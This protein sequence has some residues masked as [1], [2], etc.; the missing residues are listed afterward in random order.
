[1]RW[2][3][4]LTATR[5]DQAD[6]RAEADAFAAFLPKLL[7]SYRLDS[8]RAALVG[9]SNGANFIA[10]LMLLHPHLV[11]RAALLRAM[12][13]L[14]EPPAP[15][16]TDAAVLMVTGRSDPYGPY[17]PGLGETLRKLGAHVEA[18][19]VQAGH[20]LTPEDVAIVQDWVSGLQIHRE[21]I[22][23]SLPE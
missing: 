9:Y 3:R 19:T 1:M 2:F 18:H 16:L 8:A 21:G 22:G 4:R 23:T 12:L 6:V 15:D 11:R 17:A 13:A 7:R 20:E 10:A 5:F 14:D